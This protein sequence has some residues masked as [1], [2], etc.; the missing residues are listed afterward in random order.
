MHSMQGLGCRVSGLGFRLVP[1]AGKEAECT[2]S[3]GSHQDR[4]RSHAP[5]GPIYLL[6]FIIKREVVK[7]AVVQEVMP[8]NITFTC[9]AKNCQ[10][11]SFIILYSTH[12]HT[13]TNTH[14]HIHVCV[15]VY[16]CMLCVCVCVNVIYTDVTPF[17][18]ALFTTTALCVC[19]CVQITFTCVC[20][21]V[22]VCV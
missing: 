9:P 12:T 22:C 20:V 2:R 6:L 18:T 3:R 8:G 5:P 15:C 13:H 19:E 21:C 11:C 16:V 7:R 17:T 14:T 4:L 1:A 10:H